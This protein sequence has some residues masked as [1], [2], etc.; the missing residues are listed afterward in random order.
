MRCS[1]FLAGEGSLEALRGAD[2]DQDWRVFHRGERNWILQT[3]L[4]LAGSGLPVELTDMPPDDGLVLFHA[5][6]AVALAKR[7][8]PDSPAVL[9]GVRAD[10]REPLIADF[11]IVQNGAFADGAR[12][13]FLP[14][15]PQPGLVPR[16]PERGTRIERVVYKGFDQNVHRDFLAPAWSRALAERGMEWVTDGTHFAGPATDRE[17]L[18]WPNYRDADVIL[19]IRPADRRLWTSKPATK[20]VNAWLAGVPAILGP[21]VAYRELRRS[22]L[23]YL[24]AASA[25]EAGQALDRLAADPAL[26]RA[27]VENGRA[28][29]AEFSFETLT[30]RWMELLGETLPRRADTPE[31]RRSRKVPLPLRA[32][33]RRV[34]RWLSLRPAR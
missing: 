12:R 3:Y 9:V 28:R 13:F 31:V 2:P 20:L 19:A 29:A 34:K 1:F 15:W 4:R 24:E 27:M 7:L 14:H 16:D 30:R 22:E 23:D 10:N 18:T 5:K 8:P 11:E 17:T 32:T 26:Y 25:A 33:S 21:E 6:H